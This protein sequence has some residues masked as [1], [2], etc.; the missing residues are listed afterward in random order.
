MTKHPAFITEQPKKGDIIGHCPHLMKRKQ[1]W[2]R[3]PPK[4]VYLDTKTGLE[5][6]PQWLTECVKCFDTR[7]T[8]KIAPIV[9]GFAVWQDDEPVIMEN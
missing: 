1:H 4:T 8:L 2:S 5:I 6:E 3:F 9:S 7:I